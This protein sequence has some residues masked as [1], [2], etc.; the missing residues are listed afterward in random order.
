[1]VPCVKGDDL[2]SEKQRPN[3]LMAANLSI[4]YYMV[5]SY[6][7]NLL[8]TRE[9]NANRSYQ[10]IK[11]SFL[12]KVEELVFPCFPEQ[13][14]KFFRSSM[15]LV[16]PGFSRNSPVQKTSAYNLCGSLLLARLA[17]RTT[18][19]STGSCAQWAPL[20]CIRYWLDYKIC[21]PIVGKL[22]L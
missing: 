11:A 15:F 20:F 18:H 2:G 21:S 5:P 10:Q 17:C 4:Y 19:W 3:L 7:V 8:R 6:K 1:M 9:Q 13:R 16:K 22:L 14:R 12:K